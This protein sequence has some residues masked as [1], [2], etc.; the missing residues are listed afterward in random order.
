MNCIFCGSKLEVGSPRDRPL[1]C[2][3]SL[4]KEKHS[5]SLYNDGSDSLILLGLEG[6]RYYDPLYGKI[7]C[8]IYVDESD[9][10]IKQYHE[11]L[12]NEELINHMRIASLLM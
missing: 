8:D 10:L 1:I 7:Y 6:I 4:A 3:D 2:P 12:T 5:Y 9:R 11:P